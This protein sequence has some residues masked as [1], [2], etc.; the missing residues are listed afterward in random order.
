MLLLYCAFLNLYSQVDSYCTTQI[1]FL[2]MSDRDSVKEIKRYLD[3]RLS[4]LEI[5]IR[6]SKNSSSK[7]KRP[8]VWPTV[9]W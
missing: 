9:W 6:K 2:N 3:K 4:G 1:S 7:R 8:T 5:E